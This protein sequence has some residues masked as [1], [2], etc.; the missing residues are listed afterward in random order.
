MSEKRTA[1]SLS[2]LDDSQ[3]YTGTCRITENLQRKFRVLGHTTSCTHTDQLPR[4]EEG[5]KM[6][7]VTQPT[8]P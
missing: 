5:T 4:L 7:D 1:Q 6:K 8:G 3:V 2:Q